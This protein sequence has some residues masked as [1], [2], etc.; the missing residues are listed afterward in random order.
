MSVFELYPT[1]YSLI[2]TQSSEGR[3]ANQDWLLIPKVRKYSVINDERIDEEILTMIFFDGW[4]TKHYSQVQTLRLVHKRFADL[5]FKRM[6]IL[7]VTTMRI[8]DSRSINTSRLNSIVRSY[9]NVIALSMDFT[10]EK[11][12]SL[13]PQAA[14]PEGN[15]GKVT[16]TRPEQG[17]VAKAETSGATKNESSD[18]AKMSC[19]GAAGEGESSQ[20][21]RKKKP[22]DDHNDE[23]KKSNKKAK[24]EKNSE[25]VEGSSAAEDSESDVWAKWREREKSMPFRCGLIAPGKQGQ[26]AITKR[27]DL[28]AQSS[29][30]PR[31]GGGLALSPAAQLSHAGLDASVLSSMLPALG[32]R[33]LLLSLKGTSVSDLQCPIIA[34]CCPLLEYLELSKTS[35]DTTDEITDV[36]AIVLLETLPAL[37]YLGL[38]RTAITS[39]T[40]D[41]ICALPDQTAPPLHVDITGCHA[42][43]AAADVERLPR[44]R[45]VEV[46]IIS[47]SI[48]KA[49][50][51]RLL[52][53]RK[54]W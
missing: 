31:A 7:D 8:N 15:E 13:A 36:G 40:L 29:K 19:A 33:L 9:T 27:A 37:Q 26:D 39:D 16:I 44:R 14:D 32:A 12:V 18:H 38:A 23:P 41:A 2:N 35:S 54:G 43:G 28:I 49:H 51:Y 34:K 6:H 20:R 53:K 47:D 22:S 52:G 48:V 21:K 46:G 42:V 30:S 50:M 1:L 4:L 10:T 3:E 25:A 5:A 17:G 11:V 24:R 45:S